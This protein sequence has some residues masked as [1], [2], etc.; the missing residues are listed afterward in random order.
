MSR[1]RNPEI[2]VA[3]LRVRGIDL[4]LGMDFLRSRRLF[5]SYAGFRMF[6]SNLSGRCG[7]RNRVPVLNRQARFSSSRRIASP[8]VAGRHRRRAGLR[9]VGGAQL[10][11]RACR[12]PRFSTRSAS[13]GMSNE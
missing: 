4:I 8:I 6:L 11:R 13:S 10:R 1:S 9:D 2:V 5:L 7:S 3:D 12:G